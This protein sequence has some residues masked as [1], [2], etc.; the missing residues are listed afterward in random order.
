MALGQVGLHRIGA[1]AETDAALSP[2]VGSPGLVPGGAG[3]GVRGGSHQVC[4][5]QQGEEQRTA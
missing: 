1:L 3:V 4:T 5:L 2:E